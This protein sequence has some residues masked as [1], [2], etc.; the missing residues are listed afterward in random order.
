MLLQLIT[1]V[2]TIVLSLIVL[3]LVVVYHPFT[4]VTLTLVHWNSEEVKILDG[5]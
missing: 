5:L 3:V 2:T 4:N 1:I